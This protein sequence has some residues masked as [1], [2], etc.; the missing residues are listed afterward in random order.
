MKKIHHLKLPLGKLLEKMKRERQSYKEAQ[1]SRK[2][3]IFQSKTFS[4][5]ILCS[6]HPYKKS[7][8]SSR[9]VPI[10][11]S[12][13]AST[14][15]SNSSTLLNIRSARLNEISNDNVP[16]SLSRLKTVCSRRSLRLR[17]ESTRACKSITSNC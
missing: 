4:T 6:S 1:I 17:T 7:P 10:N 3:K 16:R 15:S 13:V 11:L 2:N 8:F 14:K 9:K 5:K 12:R